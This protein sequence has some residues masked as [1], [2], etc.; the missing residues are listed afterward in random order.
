MSSV[1]DIRERSTLLDAAHG[2]LSVTYGS[3]PA[4]DGQMP[5]VRIDARSATFTDRLGSFSEGLV[6]NAG[7]FVASVDWAPFPTHSP[8]HPEYLA[9]A[10]DI[11]SSPGTVPASTLG[12]PSDRPGCVDILSLVGGKVRMEYRVCVPQGQVMEARWMPCGWDTF[13]SVE[14]PASLPS[15]DNPHSGRRIGILACRLSSRKIALYA[16]PLPEDVLAQP[17]Y[18]TGRPSQDGQRQ[19]PRNTEVP[20]IELGS[21][22]DFDLQSNARQPTA[23]AWGGSD[24]LA[25]GCANGTASIW[26]VG[27][28]LRQLAGRKHQEQQ[29]SKRFATAPCHSFALCDTSIT[30]LSFL[31]MPPR[32]TKAGDFI[33]E[34]ESGGYEHDEQPHYLLASCVSGQQK[35]VDLWSGGGSGVDGA[36]EVTR[37]R[38]PFY[39]S[40]FMPYLGVFVSERGGDNSV[41][42]I[43][44]RP[45]VY[46][47]S[48]TVGQHHGRC[49][50][51]DASPFHPLIVSGG[52]DGSV[53][54]INVLSSVTKGMGCAPWNVYRLDIHRTSGRLRMVDGMAKEAVTKSSPDDFIERVLAGGEADAKMPRVTGWHP[55]IRITDVR[56]CPNIQGAFLLASSTAAGL[57]RL[58]WIAPSLK[59]GQD[60]A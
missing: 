21:M 48:M 31:M 32:S 42:L 38:E 30:A 23:M 25:V 59:Q 8:A 28:L 43:H 39:A 24:L 29:A 20:Y 55:V 3:V 16:V 13:E 52:A 22:L 46:G 27:Y 11:S 1:R 47:R 58:D 50:T 34:D 6:Y 33:A 7:S 37:Q 40:C 15:Q 35:I 60:A 4:R 45:E 2:D 53:K 54:I 14:H 49:T 57:V 5:L 51:L 18:A 56:W 44:T 12:Q 19:K 9:V 10:L 41:R 17:E 36:G 26:P